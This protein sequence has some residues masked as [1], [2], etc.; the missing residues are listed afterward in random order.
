[1]KTT[2]KPTT[3]K[4]TKKRATKV[5]PKTKTNTSINQ[6]EEN[7]KPPFYLIDKS[8]CI[9]F[10]GQPFY[11]DRNLAEQTAEVR[12]SKIGQIW[13]VDAYINGLMHNLIMTVKASSTKKP[14]RTRN[15]RPGDIYIGD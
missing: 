13:H 9:D 5:T 15:K 11:V 10:N 4:K 12:I 7:V 1:M 2:D 6:V 3:K 8:G 14:V